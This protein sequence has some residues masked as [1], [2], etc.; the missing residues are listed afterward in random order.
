MKSRIFIDG[1]IIRRKIRMDMLQSGGSGR[2]QKK[3][4]MWLGRNG[5]KCIIRNMTIGR[6]KHRNILIM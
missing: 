6:E 5:V 4:I 1:I 3:G 2:N